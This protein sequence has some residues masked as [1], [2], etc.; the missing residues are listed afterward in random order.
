MLCFRYALSISYISSFVKPIVELF[1]K[2]GE[3]KSKK[4]P[5]FSVRVVLSSE[6]NVAGEGKKALVVQTKSRRFATVVLPKL[7]K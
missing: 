7:H 4:R 1:L 6:I 5:H 3:K 2:K